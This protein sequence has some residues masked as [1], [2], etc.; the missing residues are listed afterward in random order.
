VVG[1]GH[2]FCWSRSIGVYLSTDSITITEVGNTLTGRT[3]L[4]EFSAKIGEEGPE[5]VLKELLE[6]HLSRQERRSLPV[7]LGLGPEQTFF[8][9]RA[10]NFEPH[11]TP[12]LKY[13]LEASGGAGSLDSKKIAADYF[14]VAKLKSMGN[15]LWTLAACR[16]D[17]AE[18][19]LAS[20]REAGIRNFRLQPGPLPLLS[21]KKLL[22]RR[23]KSWKIIVHV[24][25]NAGGGLAAL[26]IGGR[27]VLWREFACAT[28]QRLQAVCSA[29][30]T[31]RAHAA[32]SLGNPTVDGVFL[33]GEKADELAASIGEDLGIEAVAEEG[34]GFTDARCS[35]GLALSARG[36]DEQTTLD[37]FRTLREAPS[38]W[39]MFPTKRAVA[40]VAATACMGFMMWQKDHE[41]I[42]KYET[43][44][45]QNASYEWTHGERTGE[46]SKERKQ[47]LAE[48]QA[49]SKFLS[50]RITWSDYL[51]DLP[52]RLPENACLS[53]IWA[54]NEMKETNKKKQGRKAK[55]SLTLRGVTR[56]AEGSAAPEEIDAF[57][58]SLRNVDLLRR[59]FPQVE[60]AEIKWRREGS[61][62][63]AMFTIIAMPKNKGAGEE[64]KE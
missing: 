40:V 36:G 6:T 32:T 30:Q 38:L 22:P 59:D 54:V 56:F 15:Q 60:L 45:R 58:E 7:C 2:K 47:L 16:R 39:A 24:L 23:Y 17:L 27:V 19:L 31:V 14:K 9:T 4:K 37:L 48:V 29:I 3:V 44:K 52:T 57:L 28:E 11:E 61:S 25:L 12:S 63:I 18:S 21:A 55:K 8:L 26:A 46:I 34:E 10:A 35:Y 41:L 49:V 50:T 53:N 13:L 42:G 51:S 43:F 1:I 64:E 5:V 20:I 62:D 33:Q